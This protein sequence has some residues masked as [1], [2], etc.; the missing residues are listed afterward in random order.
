MT[1]GTQ[2]VTPKQTTTYTAT[3]KGDS[4]SVTATATVTVTAAPPTVTITATPATVSSGG[5]ST[6]TVA[7]TNATSVVV[8]NNV[9]STTY[10]LPVTGGTQLVNP[11]HTATYTATATGAGGSATATTTVTVTA[12]PTATITANP[13]TVSSGGASST[14]TVVATNATSVVISNNVD[15]TTYTLP[16]TGGTQLVNPIQ[17]T[18]YTATVRSVGGSVTAT[19]TVKVAPPAVTLMGNPASATV[20]AG[21]QQQLISSDPNVTWSIAPSTSG[22]ISNTGLFT[23]GTVI[24]VVTVTATDSANGSSGKTTITVI[25]FAITPNPASVVAGQTVYLTANASATW[26]ITNGNG[27]I[28]NLTTASTTATYTAPNTAGTATIKATAAANSSITAA[29]TVNIAALTVTPS[30]ANSVEGYTQQFR[31]NAPVTWAA[32]CGTIDGAGLFTAP[33]LVEDCT[34]TATQTATAVTATALDHV[35]VA[36]ATP[37]SAVYTY[38]YDNGRTGLNPNETKLS[39]SAV[40][41]GTN[42]GMLGSWTLDGS[43]FTQPL[44]VPG[45]SIQN[46]TYNVLYVCTENDSVYAL[47]AD[48]P[49]AVLWKSNFLTSAATIGQGYAGGRT[50]IGGNVGITGT[51]V[52]DPVRNWMYFVVRTTEGGNQVQRLH[53]IDITTGADVLPA[54][55]INPVVS[56]TGV[57]NDGAGHVAFLPLTENQRSALLLNY[58]IVYMTFGSFGDY[59]PYHGWLVAFDGASLAFIDAYNATP[60]SGGGGSW[61][62]GSGPAGDSNGNV[63]FA[64]GNGRPNATALFDPPYDLPNSLLKVKVISGKLTLVDYFSPYNTTCLTADDL[65]VGSSGPTLIPDQFAGYSTATIGSKEGRVYLLDQ[66]DLG[67]FHSGN[68][69]QILSSVLFNPTACGQAAFNADTS[70]RVY[71]SPAYWNGNI[72]FGSAFGAL[73]QYNITSGKLVQTA[74]SAYIFQANGELGRGPLAIVSSNGTSDAIVWTA[75]NDLSGNGWLRAFDATNVANALYTSN[76]GGG[77]NFIVPMVSDGHVYVTGLAT[78]YQYGLLH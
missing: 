69:S 54:A 25:P 18:T 12:S 51:P 47:N 11:T 21:Q 23:A 14:L 53:A 66:N 38:K 27:S 6:L 7:A 78:V 76:F 32:S 29:D 22:T 31:A 52:I 74:L 57:G 61:M 19:F 16:V 49:G 37:P 67:A 34:V 26:A 3:A 15:G 71:G 55:L 36:N 1:G 75:E 59:D 45:V 9:D 77:S 56:G 43:I 62:A 10:T 28:T 73:Q 2:L 8:S 42:F 70:M 17:T 48:V 40:T 5:A 33:T 13:T 46:V 64:T 50:S 20:I 65:D 35:I 41:N 58:G 24:G 68:D 60:N 4:G 30:T 63:Y 39:V 44:Y 72:Y